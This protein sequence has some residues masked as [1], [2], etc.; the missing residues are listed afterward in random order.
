MWVYSLKHFKTGMLLLLVTVAV[1]AAWS[2]LPHLFFFIIVTC[3]GG[4]ALF[5]LATHDSWRQ[6]LRADPGPPGY[7]MT[8]TPPPVDSNIRTTCES[9]S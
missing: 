6:T 8:P 3:V 4:V 1:S 7:P 2:Y 5:G 9:A